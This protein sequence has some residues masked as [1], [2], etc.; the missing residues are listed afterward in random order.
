MEAMN[1][2]EFMRVVDVA[3]Q[4]PEHTQEMVK[5]LAAEGVQVVL[6][7]RAR[8][9]LAE[10]GR[11]CIDLMNQQEFLLGGLNELTK[12]LLEVGQMRAA[13]TRG[14]AIK[15]ALLCSFEAERKAALGRELSE[16]SN[17][18]LLAARAGALGVKIGF[19]TSDDLDSIM[20]FHGFKRV[21]GLCGWTDS[22]QGRCIAMLNKPRRLEM[23]AFDGELL[24]VFHL[25]GGIGV[26][27]AVGTWVAGLL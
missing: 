2:A 20:E 25:D 19:V 16:L 8:A 17:D 18:E 9:Q 4:L 11:K 13:D 14:R 26:H 5:G 1:I 24:G 3:G 7:S 22:P 21:A 23:V 27:H 10:H 12:G 15:A 6:P